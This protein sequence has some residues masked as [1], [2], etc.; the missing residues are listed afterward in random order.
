MPSIPS[1]NIC[2][3]F[4]PNSGQP[5]RLSCMF[6]IIQHPVVIEQVGGG[7]SQYGGLKKYIIQSKRSFDHVSECQNLK[8]P[9]EYTFLNLS[10]PIG[11]L[12][13]NV[14]VVGLTR[15]N[16]QGRQSRW[17]IGESV[18]IAYIFYRVCLQVVA[19]FFV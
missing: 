11:E 12:S 17:N 5:E 7:Y 3:P 15:Q 2:I 13:N 19:K 14:E 10:V 8:E 4:F 16:C 18:D 1:L 9:W 6:S